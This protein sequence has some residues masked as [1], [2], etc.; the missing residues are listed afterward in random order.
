MFVS[1]SS[2]NYCNI[3]QAH[4]MVRV[5]QIHHPLISFKVKG[6][7]H[8]GVRMVDSARELGEAE[9]V[10]VRDHNILPSYGGQGGGC[11]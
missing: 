7:I 1:Y 6:N 5:S 4:A 10:L 2:C 8:G 9:V 11:T 3:E